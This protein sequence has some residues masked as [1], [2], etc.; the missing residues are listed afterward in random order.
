[1]K[2]L[3]SFL[4]LFLCV[5]Y[6]SAQTQTLRFEYDVAGNRISMYK[7]V[8]L[9]Q[10]KKNGTV[11]SLKLKPQIE[12]INE[13]EVSI[14]PN[15]TKGVLRVEI[16]GKLPEKPI[17]YIL[18]DLSGKII[19]SIQSEDMEHNFDMTNYV[20]AIYLLRIIIDEKSSVWKI[21]KE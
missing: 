5:S 6:S 15:P 2:N 20:P 3:F 1:M 12:T 14:Y 4:L 8:T 19:A 17:K 16:K 7:V 21:I 18:A 11:D 9:S 10:V 13:R